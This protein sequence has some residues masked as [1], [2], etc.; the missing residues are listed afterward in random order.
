MHSSL[1][2][3]AA[4]AALSLLVAAPAPAARTTL[5]SWVKGNVQML[6]N[7]LGEPNPR[8]TLIHLNVRENG[9]LVD[10]IW[11]RGSFTCNFCFPRHGTHA[12]VILDVHTRTQ[13]KWHVWN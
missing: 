12:D 9:R 3:F 2:T 13:I 1:R 4:I 5:P 8:I 7:G 10:H 11:M 6:A